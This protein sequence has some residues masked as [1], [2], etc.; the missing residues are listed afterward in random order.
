M[1]GPQVTCL[2]LMFGPQVTCLKLMFGPQVT[3]LKLMFG[4]QVTCFYKYLF[5][6][7]LFFIK[8]H[9]HC[10]SIEVSD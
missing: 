9:N 4:P 5:S 10:P 6:A 7:V 2:K 8:V 3:C 1:F